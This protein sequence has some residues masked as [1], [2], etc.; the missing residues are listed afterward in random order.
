ME[1]LRS[2]TVNGVDIAFID[3]AG[4]GRPIVMLHGTFG[5]G[6]NFA[7]LGR[8]LSPGA[9][10]IAPDQRGHGNSSHSDSYSNADFVTDAAEL[11][12][13]LDLGPVVVLGHSR[14]GIT[15][16]HLA[17][18]HPDLVAA[19]IIEDVGPVMRSPEIEHPVLDVRDWPATGA[20]EEQLADALRAKGI[21][22]PG[23]FMQSAEPT[24]NGHWRLLFDWN[25]MMDVQVSGIGDWWDKWL[26]STC[27]ALVLRGEHST[28]LPEPLAR[29]MVTRRSNARLVQFPDAAHWIH[30]DDPEGVAEVV[31]G[32]LRELDNGAD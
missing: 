32:F 22:D 31:A 16:Y 2:A 13:H 4:T 18:Q 7:R 25:E 23:F 29:E 1:R 21:P 30:D 11:I 28:L 5:R 27:P 20:T 8:D 10:V 26:S 9:R 12:R 6:S 3:S 19:L 24:A 14:G 17:A 15:A